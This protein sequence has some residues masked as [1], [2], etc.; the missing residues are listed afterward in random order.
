MAELTINSWTLPIKDLL[1]TKNDIVFF[2]RRGKDILLFINAGGHRSYQLGPDN[3]F[4]I[5]NSILSPTF[6]A[7]HL[8]TSSE[9][10]S[11]HSPEAKRTYLSVVTSHFSS[12]RSI[13]HLL[14]H[15]FFACLKPRQPACTQQ[16][17]SC[18]ESFSQVAR[19]HTSSRL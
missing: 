10:I 6:Q 16:A 14:L 8:S 17:N 4:L 18:K 9:D 3:I 5:T 2:L 7:L 12:I 1:R 19:I 13:F 11:D 15:T